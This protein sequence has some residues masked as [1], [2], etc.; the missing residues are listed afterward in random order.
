MVEPLNL[1]NFLCIY[2]LSIPHL[3]ENKFDF[4]IN[5]L[6]I[7]VLL[8]LIQVSVERI[9]DNSLQQKVLFSRKKN[10]SVKE[11]LFQVQERYFQEQVKWERQH[12]RTNHNRSKVEDLL[13]I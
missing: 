11:N 6:K 13:R 2:A 1:K 3:S 8:F 5:I 12:K 4:E 7:P 10:V 9:F